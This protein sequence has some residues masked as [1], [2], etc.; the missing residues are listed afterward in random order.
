VLVYR[1]SCPGLLGTTLCWKLCGGAAYLSP[2]PND[3]GLG[4]SVHVLLPQ[5]IQFIR[6]LHNSPSLHSALFPLPFN[7][8]KFLGS[9]VSLTQLHS[10]TL[11][12][13]L[14][15]QW[16][17]LPDPSTPATPTSQY[18]KTA[19]PPTFAF[20]TGKLVHLI[21]VHCDPRLDSPIIGVSHQRL[22]RSTSASRALDDP[23]RLQ[24]SAETINK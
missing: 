22:T 19:P 3:C 13:A 8:T 2:S 16:T 21:G 5:R 14:P 7:L 11:R 10:S 23:F 15:F 20:D 4:N 1:A 6:L 17:L 12:A 18:M 9:F 24:R